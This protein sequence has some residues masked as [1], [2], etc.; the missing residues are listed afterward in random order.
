MVVGTAPYMSPEQARG[1]ALDVRSDLFSFGNVLY[2]MA[3][4]RPAFE[5]STT[6]LLFDAILNREPDPPSQRNPLVP[7]DLDRI[8]GKAL[9]KERD[10]R[11][12][13]ARDMLA[14]LRRLRRDSTS[15]K[16]AAASDPGRAEAHGACSPRT[17]RVRRLLA[18]GAFAS[19]AIVLGAASAA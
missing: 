8:V 13:T 5:G 17:S 3:T 9:E 11:Y 18:L 12:Q 4:G 10:V 15:G 7:P 6:A 16:R 14:D 19:A 2:E 1:S